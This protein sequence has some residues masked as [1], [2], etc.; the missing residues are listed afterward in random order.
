[1]QFIE[2]FH[3]IVEFRMDVVV[4]EFLANDRRSRWGDLLARNLVAAAIDGVEQRFGEIYA[5]AEK[6]H[7]FSQPHR[8]NAACDAV[9]VAPIGSHEVVIF[10]LQRRRIATDLDTVLLEILRHVL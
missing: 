2:P 9:I 6:L 4:I 7:L 1:M 5:S 8:R 3:H 10:V